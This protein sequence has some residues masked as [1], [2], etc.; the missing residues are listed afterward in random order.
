MRL[1][2]RVKLQGIALA[3]LWAYLHH[4]I[5]GVRHVWMDATHSVSLGFGRASAQFTLVASLL[6]TL[7][8]GA[9]MF[10]F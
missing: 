10:F 8:V 9:R 6:L 4:F 1:L 7:A 3:L 2:P 5:A